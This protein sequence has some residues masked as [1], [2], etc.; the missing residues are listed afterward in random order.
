MERTLKIA[1]CDDEQTYLDILE[2]ECIQFLDSRNQRAEIA[3][4]QRGGELLASEREFD[5]ILLDVELP[6][7]DGFSVAEEWKHQQRPGKIIF[8]TSHDEWVQRAFKVQAFRYLYKNGSGQDLLEALE[9]AL[10]EMNDNE[11][12]MLEGKE[13]SRFVYFREIRWIEALGDEIAVFLVGGHLIVRLSL[14]KIEGY[15]DE[16]FQRIHKGYIINFQYVE[17]YN[18]DRLILDCGKEFQISKR[19]QKEVKNRY[20]EYITKYAKV[21]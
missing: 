1:I 19:K 14:K 21:I 6:D 13:E 20:F 17:H 15:L 11:G 18:K 5:I 16:R 9:D 8:I 3:C 4:F 2:D 12:I 7:M 10:K